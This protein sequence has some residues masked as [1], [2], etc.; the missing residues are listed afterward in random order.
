MRRQITGP[1]GNREYMTAL[2]VT[3]QG[4]SVESSGDAFV[5]N[6]PV[7]DGQRESPGDRIDETSP[8]S[9]AL[10]PE[11]G[12]VAIGCEG[13]PLI[14][15]G[16]LGRGRIRTHRFLSPLVHEYDAS[17]FRLQL[18]HIARNVVEQFVRHHETGD[19]D[20]KFGRPADALVQGDGS[21]AYLDRYRTHP[22][23]QGL[24]ETS[25]R[26]GKERTIA[27]A[28][29]HQIEG[30]RMLEGIV[31]PNHQA[32]KRSGEQR[33]GAGAG[34]EVVTRLVSTVEPGV[35]V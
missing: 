31:H 15:P 27:C 4:A 10:T 1:I 17:P 8:T 23:R 28:D 6:M 29:V 11:L 26:R 24:G 32:S 7:V 34:T 2:A 14:E 19:S 5:A 9:V 18:N 25:E 21:V 3:G 30:V 22:L 16:V 33:C 20:W 13:P 12:T 35:A